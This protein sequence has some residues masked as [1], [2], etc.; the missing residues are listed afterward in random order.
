M[1]QDNLIWLDLE[2]TGVDAHKDHMLEI[3]CL[4]TD[5]QL[6]IIAQGPSIVI[7]QPEKHLNGMDPYVRDMHTNSGLLHR[8]ITSP[9]S[10]DLAEKDCWERIHRV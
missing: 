3:A 5:E 10:L 7:Q 4:V 6:N 8:V 9:I 1:K 2:M